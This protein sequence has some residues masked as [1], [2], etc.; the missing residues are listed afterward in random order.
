MQVEC[1][2]L[3]AEKYVMNWLLII[4]IAA[5]GLTVVTAL[6]RGLG[7]FYQAAERSKAGDLDAAVAQGLKQNKMMTQRVL[8]QGIAVMLIVVLGA[9]AGK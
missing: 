1:K 2:R 3:R 7:A 4:L 8:F 5:C 6:V 9:L